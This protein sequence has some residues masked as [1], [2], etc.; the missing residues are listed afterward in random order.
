MSLEFVTNADSKKSLNDIHFERE[1]LKT[2]YKNVH[3]VTI[4][5][6][7]AVGNAPNQATVSSQLYYLWGPK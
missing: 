7:S 2:T 1:T 4:R 3:N 5:N 6:C